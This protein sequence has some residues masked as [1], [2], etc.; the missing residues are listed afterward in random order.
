MSNQK[1]GLKKILPGIKENIFLAEHTTFK[2]GGRANYF[3]ESKTKQDLIKAVLSAKKLN[4]PFFILGGG[5]NILVADKGYKGLVI[6]TQNSKFRTS[7]SI[8]F[9]ELRDKQN[10]NLKL[11]TI[12]A[13][14]GIELKELVKMSLDKSLSGLEWAIGI[15]GTVGGAVRGNAGAFGRAI[16]DIIK[17]VEVLDV[18]DLKFKNYKLRDCQFGY[19]ESIFKRNPNLI[20][21]SVVFQMKIGEKKDIQQKIKEYLNYR[22]AN[23]PLEFFSA[24]SVFVNPKLQITNY[25]LFKKFPE[26]EKFKKNKQI[27]ASWLIEKCGLKGEI[28]GKAQI[29]AKHCNFIINF[30]NAK[31]KDILG[32]IN[33]I[34]KKVKEKFDIEM[35]EE[36]KF[37]GF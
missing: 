18:K 33:L 5:S 21:F 12:E 11:K 15:P 1:L 29:S 31:A 32:L 9:G 2:I 19:R 28:I 4:L 23:H 24:G 30:G 35:Q 14:S 6:R 26:I 37:L 22:K 17:T 36:I 27:P 25:G 13:E 34:K 3:F 20:I 16:A 7:H 8:A 10:Y